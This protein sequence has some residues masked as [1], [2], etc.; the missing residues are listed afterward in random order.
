MT[1]IPQVSVH[2]QEFL[3]CPNRVLAGP[4][5]TRISH[6]MGT[7]GP[8]FFSYDTVRGMFRDKRLRP[9][10]AQVYLDMGL[11]PDSP[12]H[13]FL[14]TGNFNMMPVEDHDRIRSIMMAGF[15][16]SRIKQAA[17]MIRAIADDLIDQ[18]IPR[19]RANL[20]RDFSHHL[21]IRSISAYLGVPPEDVPRFENAT[22][23][24]V[25]LG[26]V[27]F[28]PGVPRLE[29]ALTEIYDYIRGLVAERRE[30][31]QADLISDLIGVQ[32]AGEQLSEP[33]LIW[34][35][36]FLLLA[37]HDTTRSQIASTAR[38]LI[39][40]GRWEEVAAAPESMPQVTQ[41]SLRM[42]PAS[43]RFPR[44]ALEDLEL[45]GLEFHENDLMALN[46][47]GAG[48]D[49]VAFPAPDRFDPSREG[50]DFDIGFGHG[51]HYCLGHALARAEISESI[52][53]LTSRLTDLR[54]E[55]PIEY[56]TGGVIAGPEVLEVSFAKRTPVA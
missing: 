51:S 32:E 23:E 48:R 45:E 47:A 27:P 43:Y 20:V 36:V 11:S 22:V 9:K 42:Y 34:C 29:A 56:V 5:G 53:A 21:S 8:E 35:I 44:V 46:I 28:M 38:A 19:G 55:A 26:T 13:E 30:N 54:I 40:S 24:L 12:I 39:E 37:G 50:L 7:S 52:Q 10:T 31:R 3:Q 25:L 49:P 15:R 33:E 6:G 16:P 2:N 41:E 18:M 17:P 1:E 14:V 4:D